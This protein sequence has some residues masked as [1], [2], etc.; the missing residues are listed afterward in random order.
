MGF[1]F[2]TKINLSINRKSVHTFVYN[3]FT[4][5]SLSQQMSFEITIIFVLQ[6]MGLDV[7]FELD[8]ISI[9]SPDP[10]YWCAQIILVLVPVL[11][12]LSL[13]SCF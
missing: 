2:L 8:Y 6:Y 5:P 9:C 7:M 12:N 3:L 11:Y 4:P 1:L 10:T 13:S